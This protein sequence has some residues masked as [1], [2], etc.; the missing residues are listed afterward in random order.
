MCIYAGNYFLIRENLVNPF[1]ATNLFLYPLKTSEK[2]WFSDVFREHGKRTV[3]S[4]GLIYDEI[5]II[6][7][8][9]KKDADYLKF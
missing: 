6:G 8:R 9:S 1:H 7:T 4:I 3:T 2:L 5:L